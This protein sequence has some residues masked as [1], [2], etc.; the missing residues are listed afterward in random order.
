MIA[1][2]VPEIEGEGSPERDGGEEEGE[3]E[4]LVLEYSSSWMFEIKLYKSDDRD[5]SIVFMANGHW[6]SKL[7]M[8]DLAV[9]GIIDPLHMLQQC[10]YKI[11]VTNSSTNT[12]IHKY[13]LWQMCLKSL[14]LS[15]YVA[16]M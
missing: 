13:S 15:I 1:R 12:Q 16:T 14:T 6:R 4:G 8:C 3:G 2:S 7:R 5:I 11:A 10:Q 9:T